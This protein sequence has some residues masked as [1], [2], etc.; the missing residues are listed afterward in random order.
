MTISGNKIKFQFVNHIPKVP[1]IQME[2][3]AFHFFNDAKKTVTLAVN[4][5]EGRTGWQMRTILLGPGEEN[6]PRSEMFA[7]KKGMNT[8][9]FDLE[10][11]DYAT[12]PYD[13]SVGVL[14]DEGSLV[15]KEDSRFF[16]LN[17]AEFEH[18]QSK[19]EKVEK[20]VL[21]DKDEKY[22]KSLP[23]LEIRFLWITE[24]M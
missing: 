11:K 13:F 22:V 8:L 14:D 16:I 3:N 21:D 15:F 23:T 18:F 4:S 1:E 20:G 2:L 6:I 9:K 17:R 19:L 24:Y 5:P 7:L 10:E 12:G